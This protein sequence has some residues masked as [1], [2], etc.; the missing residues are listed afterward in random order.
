M[1]ILTYRI[2]RVFLSALILVLAYFTVIIIR[3]VDLQ[4]T[5]SLQYVDRAFSQVYPT[6]ALK[7]ASN[8]LVVDLDMKLH[9]IAETDTGKK[10]NRVTIRQACASLIDSL[11]SYHAR[12]I[13]VD[14]FFDPYIDTTGSENILHI[15][16]NPNTVFAFKFRKEENDTLAA[17][18]K[19]IGRHTVPYSREEYTLVQS[20]PDY[21]L[22]GIELPIHG[23]AETASLMGFA[24]IFTE[25]DGSIVYYPLFHRMAGVDS[26]FAGLAT[27]VF[28]LKFQSMF[29]GFGKDKWHLQHYYSAL[30]ASPAVEMDKFGRMRIQRIKSIERADFMWQEIQNGYIEHEKFRDKFILII[31]SPTEAAGP[32]DAK[33]PMWGYHVSAITQLIEPA[34]QNIDYIAFPLLIFIYGIW[35][36][37]RL[38]PSPRTHFLIEKGRLFWIGVIVLIYSF[39]LLIAAPNLIRNSPLSAALFIGISLFL[40]EI[41]ERNLLKISTIEFADLH[42]VID[43][44]KLGIARVSIQNAPAH[45][46]TRAH[47]GLPEKKAEEWQSYKRMPYIEDSPNMRRTGESLYEFVMANELGSIFEQSLGIAANERKILRLRIRN[48]STSFADLPFEILRNS[49]KNFGYL[50]LHGNISIIRDLTAD[51]DNKIEWSLPLRMLVLIASPSSGGFKP[52]NVKSEI[53]KIRKSTYLLKR[54]GWLRLNILENT[55]HSQLEKLPEDSFDI[56]HFIGHG[57]IDSA[58]QSNCLVLEGPDGK[59]DEVQAEYFGQRLRHIGPKLILLNACETGTGMK[60]DVF[61]NIARELQRTTNAVVVAQQYLVSDTGGIVFSEAFYKSFAKTLSPE[62]ALVQA[63][64]FVASMRNTLPSDWVSPVFF[65]K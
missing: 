59:A 45:L 16:N 62:Y 7:K 47:F 3:N 58:T 61:I 39:P 43:E 25:R 41:V 10:K 20:W 14:I 33:Y 52:L 54:K 64:K 60:G 2:T 30:V 19:E 40:F 55:T 53:K 57:T 63:R 18:F 35:V 38:W 27:Q 46:G 5:G 21:N 4:T 17:I 23:L 37:A 56:V 29:D 42:F 34:R 11:I 48:E 15:A 32:L 12:G 50:G 31:N 24:D 36:Y 65:I 49:T 44:P 26:I 22:R 8:L 6:P 13:A 9:S 28:R 1:E 51:P